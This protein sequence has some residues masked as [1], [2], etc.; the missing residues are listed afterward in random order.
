MYV[1]VFISY[2]FI[3]I[4]IKMWVC[5]C[6]PICKLLF[7][8]NF[9]FFSWCT[10]L[11]W[12]WLFHLFYQ[13]QVCTP[14]YYHITLFEQQK[15]VFYPTCKVQAN[16]VEVSLQ[17]LV[18]SEAFGFS[19]HPVNHWAILNLVLWPAPRIRLFYH[20]RTNFTSSVLQSP[21]GCSFN[22]T[23]SGLR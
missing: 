14:D 6:W 17:H 12:H 20:W 2:F 21:P 3:I 5:L 13:W 9:F 22:K 15:R 10:P 1:S 19:D 4:F 23:D 16:T 8:H 18:I 7:S 11:C